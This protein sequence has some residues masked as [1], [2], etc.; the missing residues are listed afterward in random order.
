MKACMKTTLSTL[1]IERLALRQHET[2][3]LGVGIATALLSVVPKPTNSF[4]TQSGVSGRSRR[5]T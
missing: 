4:S 2:L 5:K 1:P 3:C